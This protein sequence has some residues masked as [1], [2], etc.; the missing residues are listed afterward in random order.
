MESNRIILNYSL[1]PSIDDIE[2]MAADVLQA[3]PEEL[4]RHC[5]ELTVVVEDMADETTMDDLGVE[6]MFELLALYK[7]GKEIS[8]GVERKVAND[9]DALVL[10]RRALLDMWCEVED[11]LVGVIRQ[12]MI[13]E[14]GRFFEFSDDDVQEMADRH[15]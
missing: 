4:L 14:L 7:S 8:P 9:D 11:D 5:E 10:Y 6:D 12:A 3:L 1:P 2:A 15:Y 13:E